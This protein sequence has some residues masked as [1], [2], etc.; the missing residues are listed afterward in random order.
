M[1]TRKGRHFD[2]DAM[3]REQEEPSLTV[4][5]L[6]YFG[7]L[8]SAEEWFAWNER[9]AALS[10]RIKDKTADMPDLLAFYRAYFTDLFPKSRR[11]FWAPDPVAHLMMRPFAVIQEAF[12]HFFALQAQANGVVVPTVESQPTTHGT[13]SSSRTLDPQEEFDG[14]GVA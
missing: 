10:A 6:L 9:Y 12:E 13:D 7:R 8:L 1:P 2:A 5:N 14:A 11:R 4:G 3:M